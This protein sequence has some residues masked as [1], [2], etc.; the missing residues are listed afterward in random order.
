MVGYK[1]RKWTKFIVLALMLL[2]F[3]APIIVMMIFSFNDAR[4]LSS[5]QGFSLRWYESL[6]NNREIISSVWVSVSVA[7]IATVVSTIVGTLTAI[8]LSKSRRVIKEITLTLN[9]FPILNP[10]IVTAVGLMLLFIFSGVSKGYMTM[11]LAHIMFCIPY[12]ILAVLPR[13]RS[14]DPNITEAAM[15]LGATPTQAL[16]K[17]ILPQITPSVM[18]AALIA[19]TMSFDDF[20]ISYFVSGNGVNN[21]SMQVYAMSKRINPTINALSTILIIVVTLVLILINVIPIVGKKGRK[22]EKVFY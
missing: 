12:V 2:F 17:V 19:F 3:Y 7:V 18:S 1:D 11:L 21:I 6:F 15:D 22:N 14:L 4:S 10:E 5:W 9:E 20:V 16:T 13:L 8:G